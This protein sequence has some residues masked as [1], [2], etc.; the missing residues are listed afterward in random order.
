[1]KRILIVALLGAVCLFARSQQ[2]PAI[3]INDQRPGLYAF[4][5]ATLFTD[6][7]TK[8]EAATLLIKNGRILAVGTDVKIPEGTIIRDMKGK[9]I[10]PSFIDPYTN[11]GLPP[12][13]RSSGSGGYSFTSPPQVDPGYKTAL[14]WNA[15]IKP[16]YSSSA[17]FTVD[18]KTAGQFRKQGF[19]AVL[20]FKSDGIARGSSALVCLSDQPASKVILKSQAAAHYSFEKG[21]GGQNYPNSLF[22]SIAL[23]RQ[24][25]YDVKWYRGLEEKSYTDLSF[26]AWERNQSLPQ[27]FEVRDKLSLL[28]AD[29]IGDEFG[30]Q[31]IIKSAGDEYQMIDEVK[32]TNA[33]LIVPV[34]FPEAGKVDHPWEAN[35]VP[36]EDLKHWEMAP[37][38]LATLEKEGIPFAITTYGM[39]DISGF[40]KNIRKAVRYGLSEEAALKALS[41]VPARL[42]KSENQIGSLKTGMVANFLICSENVFSSTCTLYENWIQGKGFVLTDMNLPDYSGNYA[43]DL[44]GKKLKLEI[45]GTP[46]KPKF[47]I[48]KDDTTTY[49]ATGSISGNTIFL[50][51]KKEKE[52]TS[53]TR[54]TGW[55]ADKTFRGEAYAEDGSKSP[56]TASYTDPAEPKK[57]ASKPEDK[58]PEM[59]PVIFPFMAYGYEKEDIPA[60]QTY[61]IK[62]ATV[63]T[64][65]DAGIIKNT[66]VLVK[67][68]KIVKIGTNISDATATL[69]DG[70]GKHLTSGI[71]DEHSHIAGSGGLN[72]AT[73]AVTSEVRYND[74]IN[75]EDLSIYRQLSGGVTAA[76]VLHGSANPVGGQSAL[77]KHRWGVTPDQ[78]LIHDGAQFLKHALG[79][80]VKQ[81]RAPAFLSTRYP[82]TRMGVEAILRDAYT[83]AMDYKMEWDTYNNLSS[84]EK[85]K[86]NPPRV[87]LRLEALKDVLEEKIFITCHAY[88]QS[89]TNM[90]M[91]LAEDFGIKVHTLIHNSEGYKVADKIVKHGAYASNLPDWWAYKYEVYQAIPYNTAI[92]VHEGVLAA[93]HSDNAVVA[94]HLNLEAAKTVKYGGL[95]E[96]EAWKTV[97]LNPAKILHLDHRMGSIKTGK[98]ADLVLWNRNPLSVYAVVEKTMVDGIL[99]YDSEKD[100][101]KLNKIEAERNRIIRKIL[102]EKPGPKKQMPRFNQQYIWDDEDGTYW[103]EDWWGERNQKY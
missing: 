24:T 55:V 76:H 17:E 86:T 21:S 71:I 11:Y 16:Y 5:N 10:Y 63:W 41:Y 88:V 34:N 29:K 46:L 66:D 60:Q 83:R 4:T 25:Y 93:V 87:D 42:L 51:F 6:Y 49:T 36:L 90:I 45:S 32:K 50:T 72:E 47:K 14:N 98:D 37:A 26:D 12:G 77:I 40:L 35:L 85:A 9:F 81:S 1:M 94:R 95:S 103:L 67:N 79:E 59:G 43:M 100:Q 96:E 22:G 61:L 57:K 99:Y 73:H 31:Y 48:I 44:D 53:A 2:I 54:L 8:T 102:S 58:K 20:S 39:K 56:W 18:D 3:G 13:K 80:N 74:I 70:T 101:E 28:R 84:K 97:T 62:N 69:I 27:I 68:G 82:Q 15:A 52:A 89:E 75:P 19:S 91:K 64:N 65:E 30:I 78:L 33:T 7:R 38:N 23:L 92:Q